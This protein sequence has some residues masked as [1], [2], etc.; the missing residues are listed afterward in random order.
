MW[1]EDS[2][3]LLHRGHLSHPQG[4]AEPGVMLQPWRFVGLGW[5]NSAGQPRSPSISWLRASLTS[6]PT[7]LP[8]RRLGVR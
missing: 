5:E 3:A 6:I 4:G 7:V 2:L 1:G 8:F